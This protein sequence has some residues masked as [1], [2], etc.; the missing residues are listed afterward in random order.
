MKK[1]LVSPLYI[2]VSL[3]V[4][5]CSSLL[6]CVP[7]KTST[8]NMGVLPTVTVSCGSSQNIYTNSG[9]NTIDVTVQGTDDCKNK[10]S[11]FYLVSD[12]RSILKSFIITDGLTKSTTFSVKKDQKIDFACYGD[13]GGECSYT[14]SVP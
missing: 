11:Y 2:V 4:L 6:G 1:T 10:H 7:D 12:N 8:E 9:D 3:S 5:V 14:I 13:A